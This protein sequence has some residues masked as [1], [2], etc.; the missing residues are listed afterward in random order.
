MGDHDAM[1][2]G[3]ALARLRAAMNYWVVTTRPDGRPHSAPVWGVWLD[4][5]LWF[6]TMGQKVRNLEALPYAV[7]HLDS[8]DDVIMVQGA[9]EIVHDAALVTRA[10]EA[11]RA[12]Y[13]DGETGAPFDVYPALGETPTM[14]HVVPETGWALLEGAYVSHNTRWEF[15][16]LDGRLG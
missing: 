14:Y 9:V 8:A 2:R 12:K 6:G 4:D 5:G 3:R 16:D 15:E 13:V 1:L 7:I 10:A 11:F